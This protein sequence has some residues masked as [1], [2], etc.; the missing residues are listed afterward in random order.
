MTSTKIQE[1]FLRL[2]R[3]VHASREKTGTGTSWTYTFPDGETHRYL[4]RNI[5][6]HAEVEDS[7]ANLLIWAWNAKDYLKHRSKVKGL[8][9]DHVE[10]F[11]NADSCLTVCGDLANRLKHG[12]LTRSR[13]KKFPRLGAVKFLV[14]TSAI[15]MLT[16]GAFDVDIDIGNLDTV[17]VH[18]PV[19]DRDGNEIADVFDL[20]AAAINSLEI[21]RNEIEG[22]P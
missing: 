5:R 8:D 16:F 21:L 17:E 11:I 6:S 14:P 4:L 20:A 10:R 15:R 3:M 13:C 12:E 19:L 7:V 2:E 22:I 1:L 9:P 18:I